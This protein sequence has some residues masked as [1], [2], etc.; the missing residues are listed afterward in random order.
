M[1]CGDSVVQRQI[2][3]SADYG[4]E[5]P[6]V[7]IEWMAKIK[8]KWSRYYLREYREDR[9]LTLGEVGAE[10]G[11][12]G[13]NLSKIERGVVP[14]DQ[15]VLEGLARVYRVDP[16]ELLSHAP[17]NAV[18]AARLLHGL[19]KTVREQAVAVIRVLREQAKAA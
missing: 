10:I 2:G 16:W 12:S 7:I 4:I 17:G 15:E 19:P 14:F 6:P 18:D 11:M 8:P 5:P 1:S 13:T 3:I 9:E